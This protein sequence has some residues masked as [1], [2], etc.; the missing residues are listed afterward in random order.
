[1]DAL[2]ASPTLLLAAAGPA[3][4]Q[5]TQVLGAG[6]VRGGLRAH[7]LPHLT[8]VNFDHLLWAAD[9]NFVRGEDSFV[10]AQWAGAPFVWQI[11]PQADGAHEAK[12]EAFLAAHL[13]GAQ[14]DWATT[15]R[16]LWGRWNGLG[17]VL[18]MPDMAAWRAHCTAWRDRLAAQA[19][20]CTQ[21]L[22]FAREKG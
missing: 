9:L 13:A 12:L 14:G 17:G 6:L 5:V 4:Q 2:A 7:L 15:C 10:R 21:L 22:G 1:M 20:L 16:A 3:S 19:D 18:R 8:Q 11:Y